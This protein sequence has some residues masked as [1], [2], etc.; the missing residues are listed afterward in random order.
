M[1]VL[2]SPEESGTHPIS[3]MQIPSYGNAEK[4]SNSQPTS[5]SDSSIPLT[6][7]ACVPPPVAAQVPAATSTTYL[8]G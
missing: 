3:T 6:P 4:K 8:Y 2:M 1:I 5:A 7:A